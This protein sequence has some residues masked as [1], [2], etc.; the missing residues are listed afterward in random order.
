MSLASLRSQARGR[1]LEWTAT[2]WLV[3]KGYR[4]LARNYVAKGGEIDV[5]ALSPSRWAGKPILCFVEVRGRETFEA[6][7]ESV[8]AAKQLRLRR[9]AAAFVAQHR[10]WSHLPSRFDLVAIERHGGLRHV[11]RA[12]D[13]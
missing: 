13:R 2:I 3:I 10:Q 9:A 12:F 4:V 7:A 1:A 6:A 5:I 8:H 11:R